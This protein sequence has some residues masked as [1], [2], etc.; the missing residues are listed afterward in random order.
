MDPEGDIGAK[1]R[2]LKWHVSRKLKV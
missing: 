1:T 2:R